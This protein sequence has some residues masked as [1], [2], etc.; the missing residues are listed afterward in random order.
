MHCTEL[1]QSLVAAGLGS[2]QS[3][4]QRLARQYGNDIVINQQT[5]RRPKPITQ[6]KTEKRESSKPKARDDT[7]RSNSLK[8]A[9]QKASEVLANKNIQVSEK[10][11][12]RAFERESILQGSREQVQKNLIALG[13]TDGPVKD[14]ASAF[15]RGLEKIFLAVLNTLVSEAH[16]SEVN[17]PQSASRQRPSIFERRATLEA[18]I[19]AEQTRQ[20][21]SLWNQYTRGLTEWPATRP[22]ESAMMLG[23]ISDLGRTGLEFVSGPV[24]FL[25]DS[26]TFLDELQQS[27]FRRDNAFVGNFTQRTQQGLHSLGHAITHLPETG[28][29]YLDSIGQRLQRAQDEYARGNYFT[30]GALGN[31]ARPVAEVGLLAYG[32]VGA[33]RLLYNVSNSAVRTTARGVMVTAREVRKFIDSHNFRSPITFQFDALEANAVRLNAGIPID[34][35][36]LQKPYTKKDVLSEKAR[37]HPEPLL[38]HEEILVTIWQ[39]ERLE[40]MQKIGMAD[41]S[42]VN[43]K[44]KRELKECLNQLRDHMTP[45]DF[46]AILKEQRGVEIPKPNGGIYDHLNREWFDAKQSFRNALEGPWSGSLEEAAVL[47]EQFGNISRLWTRFE[48]LIERAKCNP[49]LTTLKP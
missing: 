13:K 9:T 17:I 5:R 35:L 37:L 33:T 29:N 7:W 2:V 49:E 45:D 30:A 27:L 46:A 42:K 18:D 12:R 39:T 3:R 20:G 26:A 22:P 14:N 32:G 21:V 23:A 44:M 36:R 38:S 47:N 6:D 34:R 43:P 40:W 25:T 15:K 16:A 48:K 19:R 41:L 10:R 11:V 8:V 1:A 4:V 31:P 24:S 28:T